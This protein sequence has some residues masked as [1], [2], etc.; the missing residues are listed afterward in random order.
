VPGPE[1]YGGLAALSGFSQRGVNATG[2]AAA[3]HV[4]K[5]ILNVLVV[6]QN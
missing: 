3:G 6:C 2:Q 5:G 4:D 1:V